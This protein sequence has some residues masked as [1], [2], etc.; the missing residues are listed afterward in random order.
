LRKLKQELL[1]SERAGPWYCY[2]VRC[3][4]ERRLL[5][6][7]GAREPHPVLLQR[8]EQLLRRRVLRHAR[9]LLRRERELLP[10]D[11]G[12]LRQR[13]ELLLRPD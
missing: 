12:V 4:W 9:R 10:R 5:H 13:H 11:G 6:W 8:Y 3:G 7:R 2:P 1:L